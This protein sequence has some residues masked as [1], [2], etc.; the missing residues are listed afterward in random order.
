MEN[1]KILEERKNPI[2]KRREVEVS[3]DSLSAPKIQ[4]AE[5]F[6]SEKLSAQPENI[7]IKKIKGR[8]G[9][10][11]FIILANVYDSKEDKEKVEP[12]QKNKKAGSV[13]AKEEKK[14]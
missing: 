9:S 4:E 5:N 13:E 3:V 10:S 2:F 11:N 1:F 6:L 12:R 14:E 8:F 7:K